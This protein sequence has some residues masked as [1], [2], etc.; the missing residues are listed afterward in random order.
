MSVG[1]LMSKSDSISK[2][3]PAQ[4]KFGSAWAEDLPPE[5]VAPDGN[6][7][8][9]IVQIFYQP[10]GVSGLLIVGAMLG[11]MLAITFG[12]LALLGLI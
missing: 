7:R 9:L 1:F 8:P 4:T 5:A 11:V 12:I 6:A 2:K 3:T 10:N